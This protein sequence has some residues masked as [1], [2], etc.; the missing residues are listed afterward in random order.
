MIVLPIQNNQNK[1]SLMNLFDVVQIDLANYPIKAILSVIVIIFTVIS[2]FFEKSYAEE[3]N[4]LPSDRNE[5][6]SIKEIYIKY[7]NQ[8]IIVELHIDY[9]YEVTLEQ[10]LKFLHMKVLH[11]DQHYSLN[12]TSMT[13]QSTI[14]K[15]TILQFVAPI[16][17]PFTVQL[18]RSKSLLKQIE[19]QN[20]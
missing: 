9:I 1:N 6:T 5:L 14:G 3:I 19:I 17:P 10:H 7:S 11:N 4:K 15:I 12:T 8:F 18:Y 13:P 16:S 2:S 20:D